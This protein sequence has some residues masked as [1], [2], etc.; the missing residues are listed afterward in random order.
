MGA[1]QVAMYGKRVIAR[2]QAKKGGTPYVVA[3]RDLPSSLDD[4]FK[5]EAAS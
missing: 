5:L 4:G 2:R 1:A 3:A